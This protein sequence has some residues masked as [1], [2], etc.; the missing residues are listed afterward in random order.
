MVERRAVT[1][2][3]IAHR[4]GVSPMTVSAVLRDNSVHVRVS[5]ATRDRV[6][7]VA[8]EMKYHPNAVARALRRQRTNVIG[9]YSGF[10]YLDARN[11]FVS[12]IIGGLQ[13]G[14]DEHQKDL[15]LHGVFQGRSVDN[16]YAELADGR[17]DGL[18]VIAPPDD[19]LVDRLAQSKL[20]VVVV[21]DAV[22]ALP[23][24][25]AD[26][27]RGMNLLMD[28][29]VG[30]GYRRFVYREWDRS[31]DSVSRRIATFRE[32]AAR[33]DLYATE[34]VAPQQTEPGDAV[35]AEWLRRAASERTTVFVCWNDVAAYDLL[36]HCAVLGIRVPQ[37]VAIAG[38]DGLTTPLAA[39]YRLTTVRA[40]WAEVARTAVSQLVGALNGK[41]IAQETV[42]PVELICGD[43][44]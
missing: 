21:V 11:P 26:G 43:T 5:D 18:V 4:A 34:W 15:L 29:L 8:R 31:L 23:C 13:E 2:K 12:E 33:H 24:V 39:G 14:C 36:A 37:D 25:V 17:I 6:L 3:D 27:V 40:Q 19:P 38:F 42:L 41:N 1:L 10:G 16:I 7:A 28:Y 30:K 20:P 35:V 22:P 32:Y 44:A 9:L